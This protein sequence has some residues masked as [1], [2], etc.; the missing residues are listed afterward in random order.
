MENKALEQAAFE[1]TER[2]VTPIGKTIAL[3]EFLAGANWQAA[4]T[5]EAVVKIFQDRI[6]ALDMRIDTL[7]ELD[8]LLDKIK[9]LPKP[10][11]NK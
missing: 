9:A 11:L 3:T 2:H 6:D 8:D 7:W 1:A 5:V 10:P 4:Q